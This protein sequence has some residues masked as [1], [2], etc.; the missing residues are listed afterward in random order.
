MQID[1]AGIW[2]FGCR[3]F[4][5]TSVKIPGHCLQILQLSTLLKGLNPPSRLRIKQNISVF[6]S[7]A[8]D[9][10]GCLGWK[11]RRRVGLLFY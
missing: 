6:N 11:Q 4:L 8:W 3:G 10:M 9:G 5:D 7:K 1:I 2:N